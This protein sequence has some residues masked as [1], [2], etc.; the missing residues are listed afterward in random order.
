MEKDKDHRRKL[1][2]LAVIPGADD[3][4][5]FIFA[6]RQMEA[7]AARGHSVEV[8]DLRR[9]R[10]LR[11]LLENLAFYRRRLR[12][13]AP[14]VVH[15]HYGS[16]T[17][18]FS[19]YGAMGL[20]PVVVM[21][22]GSDLNPLP[23]QS[24]LATFPSHFLSQLAALGAARII[25]VSAELRRRL[26]WRRKA[27]SLIPTGVDTRKFYPGSRQQARQALGWDPLRPIVI[28]PG[29]S[30][31]KRLDV[32]TSVVEIA[33]RSLK[34][35]E[36]VALDGKIS[37]D[38]MPLVMQASD[39]LLFTSD[40][41]GSPTMVQEAMACNLPVVSVPVGDVP[42]RLR[43]VVPSYVL[44]RT[45]ELLADA[46]VGVL[47]DQARS[48]GSEIASLDVAIEPV[49]DALE[50]TYWAASADASPLPS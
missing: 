47:L 27:V 21:F 11:A 3:P 18:F 5:A 4:V 36:F 10:S 43:H 31:I 32:A 38:R 19:V 12:T 50:Q 49:L 44:P 42:E 2:V 39:C 25:C 33:R 24:L 17:G 9:R 26:W 37:P 28:A 29:H 7:V 41:E 22:R 45:P 8:F 35:I 48:N 23:Y 15:A 14:D 20:A 16:M 1:R 46:L 6:R 34:D 13:F 30:P 40:F